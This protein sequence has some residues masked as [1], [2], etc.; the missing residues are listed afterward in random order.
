[1]PTLD[2][3]AHSLMMLESGDIDNL[4]YRRGPGRFVLVYDRSWRNS[5]ALSHLGMMTLGIL[6]WPG[7]PLPNEQAGFA[8]WRRLQG[9]AMVAHSP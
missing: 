2:E 9:H 8:P 4:P 3:V 7:T 6:S 1:M 5:R